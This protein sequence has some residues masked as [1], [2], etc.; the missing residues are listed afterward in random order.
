MLRHRG[1]FMEINV[2]D[3]SVMPQDIVF[4]REKIWELLVM[5]VL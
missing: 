3:L 1:A 2:Q 5:Q 4:I